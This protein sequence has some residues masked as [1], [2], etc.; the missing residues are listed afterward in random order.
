VRI[1]LQNNLVYK[2]DLKEVQIACE[3]AGVEVQ[4]IKVLPFSEDIPEFTYNRNNIYYG[5]TTLMYN[6]YNQLCKPKGLFYNS[7]TFNMR[8]YLLRWGDRLLNSSA[9]L[10]RVHF[11]LNEDEYFKYMRPA[12]KKVAMFEKKYFIRPNGDGK[13]FDG[14]VGT[15]QEIKEMLERYVQYDNRLDEDS[16]VLIGPAYNIYKEWRLYIV[17]GKI[18]TASRYRKDFKLSKSSEDI[19]E[20]MIN[21]AEECIASYKPHENFALDICNTH[22]GEYYIIEA[23]CLNSVGFY[24]CDINKLFK[25]IITWMKN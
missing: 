7:D 14:Q 18:I 11:I 9:Q 17:G 5:S 13:E 8:T 24:H 20:S 19:P 15:Y 10:V 4:N 22:D 3:E 21:F 23:G 1:V 6:I 2:N 16:E 25:A 12:Q